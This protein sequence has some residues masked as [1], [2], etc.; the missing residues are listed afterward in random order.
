MAKKKKI[1]NPVTLKIKYT[2]AEKDM[3]TISDFL[4]ASNPI[5]RY[6]YNRVKENPEIDTKELTV[7]QKQMNN[8]S[9]L[10]NYHLLNSI[11]YQAKALYSSRPDNRQVIFGGRS[12]FIKRCQNKITK[13]EWDE[14]RLVPLYSV[15]EANQKG[16]RLFQILT[17]NTILFK[18]NRNTHIIITLQ[19]IG[20][21]Y[22]QR[23]KQLKELQN[24]R[25]LPITYQIDKEYVYITYDNEIF[26]HYEY[27]LR[28]NRVIAIDLNPN[29]IGWSVTDW[30]DDYD[31][32]LI[33]KGMV[34]LKPLNDYKNSLGVE[35]T[36]PL[37]KYVTN[38]RNHE[39]IHIAKQLFNICSHYHCESF[40]IEEL[41]MDSVTN[42][43]FEDRTRRRL[44][45]NQWNHDLLVKQITKHIKSSPTKLI[46]VKPEY[47]S[48][49]GNLV[50][51]SLNLPDPILASIEIGRR[52]FEFGTQYIYKRRPHKKTVIFPSFDLVK[53][54][55]SISLE[56]LGV[57]VPK[58]EKWTD[59]WEMVKNPEVKYR[60]PIPESQSGSPCS[61]FY[62]R[63]YLMVYNF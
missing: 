57:I 14:L 2:C 8:R 46:K 35:S 37:S 20:K 4:K 26:E 11:Q 9:D 48:I 60:V 10:I 59:V 27:P 63:K 38:K 58:L 49:I 41:Q 5:L 56:E 34:S 21:N 6:T 22:I 53:K 25:A 54:I 1:S 45:N 40:V 36:H 30:I 28:S 52:G 17:T 33:D 19:S 50:N 51:R 61:K 18:P 29:Y 31:F 16:N 15:G 42:E 7:I 13:E 39:I 62:K 43:T 32:K 23:L 44:I 3:N 24:R 12:N 55:I 47:S